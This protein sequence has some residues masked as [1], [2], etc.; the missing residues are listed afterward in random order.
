MNNKECI[1]ILNDIINNM[2]VEG[3]WFETESRTN[4]IAI[5]I[6]HRKINL[7]NIR[8]GFGHWKSMDEMFMD[9]YSNDIRFILE[10]IERIRKDMNCMGDYMFDYLSINDIGVDFLKCLY[11]SGSFGELKLK[12]QVMGYEI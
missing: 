2:G 9:M 7:Y 10:R 12:L 11:N 8:S 4:S 1:D 5:C 3:F 6:P